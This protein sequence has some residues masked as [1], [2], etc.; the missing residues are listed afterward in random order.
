M[1]FGLCLGGELTAPCRA[2]EG[3]TGGKGAGEGPTAAALS[4]VVAEA[5]SRLGPYPPLSRGSW[6]HGPRRGTQCGRHLCRWREEGMN[7]W[8]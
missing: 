8:V 6:F 3:R 4:S 2:E 7:Q 1:G 5:L